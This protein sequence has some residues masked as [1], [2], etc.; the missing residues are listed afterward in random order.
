MKNIYIVK[1]STGKYE[2]YREH[3]IFAT[4]DKEK[5]IA[6][7]K[8]FNSLKDKWCNHYSQYNGDYRWIKNYFEEKYFHKWYIFHELNDCFYEEIEV[9]V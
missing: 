1:Y 2:D 3:N 4:F 7:V 6:Y 5:V 8:K 9:R